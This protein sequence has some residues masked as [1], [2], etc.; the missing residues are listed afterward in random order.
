MRKSVEQGELFG[1]QVDFGKQMIPDNK[2]PGE[3]KFLKSGNNQYQ[4]EFNYGILSL[5]LK[6]KNGNHDCRGLFKIFNGKVICLS[7]ENYKASNLDN[8]L[9]NNILDEMHRAA[10]IFF[11]KIN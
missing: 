8:P 11:K 9:P 7:T 3:R 5:L 2:E 6:D 1:S 4:K 10:N